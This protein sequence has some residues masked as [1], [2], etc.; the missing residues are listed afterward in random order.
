MDKFVKWQDAKA[1]MASLS[2]EEKQEIDIMSDIITEIIERRQ[3]LGMSQAI[4]KGSCSPFYYNRESDKINI[5]KNWF[6][7]F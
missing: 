5:W 4:I 7:K 3:E 1:S 6:L 2:E